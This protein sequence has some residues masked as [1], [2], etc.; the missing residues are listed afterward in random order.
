MTTEEFFHEILIIIHS[1]RYEGYDHPEI[2]NLSKD[3]PVIQRAEFVEK[4]I[5]N[6]E[7]EAREFGRKVNIVPKP[8]QI[9]PEEP[10]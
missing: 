10:M 2:E 8:I 9:E 4:I 6:L 5:S 1:Y 3:H 7:N